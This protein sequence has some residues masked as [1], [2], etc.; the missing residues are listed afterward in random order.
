MPLYFGWFAIGFVALV[1]VTWVIFGGYT[2]VY[3]ADKVFIVVAVAVVAGLYR[4]RYPKFSRSIQSLTQNIIV[5]QLLLIFVYLC[6]STD[7][8]FWDTEFAAADAAIRF[9]WV[10]WHDL[11]A[12]SEIA[13]NSIGCLY[14]IVYFGQILFAQFVLPFLNARRNTEYVVCL[15]AI[16]MIS[17]VI[18]MLMPAVGPNVHFDRADPALHSGIVN[19]Y[20]TYMELRHSS[21]RVLDY[22]QLNSGLMVFP[23]FHAASTIL[24]CNAFRGCRPQLF[25][26]PVVSSVLMLF[27]VPYAGGHYLVDVF[28]GL[29]LAGVVI[30]TARVASSFVGAGLTVRRTGP[31]FRQKPLLRPTSP[32]Q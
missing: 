7:F 14:V 31:T 18:A 6:S 24:C 22:G 11:I 17:S 30:A 28:A 10:K 8:P 23:S 21:A 20:N 13:R 27:T 32:A 25:M 3:T 4:S 9:D 5:I 12:S 1:D 2:V 19:F 15:S 16:I 29:V 26:I